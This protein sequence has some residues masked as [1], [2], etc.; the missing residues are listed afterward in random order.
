MIFSDFE[1]FVFFLFVFFTVWYLFPALIWD[2]RKEKRILHIFLLI[3]SYFFYMSWDY[4]FGALI[5]LS[6]FIDYYVGMRLAKTE[7][8]S[9]RLALL[10]F[11]LITNLVFILGFFKYY[12][13][14][15]STTNSVGLHLF[16]EPAL[17]ILNIILPAGISFFTF[18]SLS[19]T[20]DVYRKEI[21]AERDFIKFALFVSFFPQLVAGPIVTAR[22]FVPQLYEIKKFENIEFRIAIRFFMLGYFKKAVL[23][24]QI[25]PTIDLIYKDPTSLHTFTLWIGSVF[26]GIQVYLDFS[27]Y[28]DMA[29]GSA[30]LLGYKLPTNFNLPFIATSVSG[31]WRRWHITLNS[32][33]RDYIYFPMGGSRVSPIRRK[34]NIWF[35]MFASGV[36]HGANWTYVFW[37]SLNGVFYMIEELYKDL[38]GK[39]AVL[40]IS[41]MGNR[42]YSAFKWFFQNTI[43]NLLFFMGAVFFRSSTFENAILHLKG[44]F[45]WQNGLFRPYMWKEFLWIS[46]LVALGHIFG[47]LIFEKKKVTNFPVTFELALY[48]VIIL[49]LCLFTPENSTPFIYF[50]F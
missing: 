46:V 2:E 38:F 13:F 37:G 4:R 29:I 31:F 33:L 27:G 26:G 1:Y 21:P 22:T 42:I 18:Q 9:W 41:S 15:A 3:A 7:S 47:Y 19:Y 35:T 8:K 50:Q 6:T 20:I 49:L 11:S 45:V 5:L 34:F 36:W 32:W 16:G 24:D 30:L 12:N 10:Y 25:A 28:T 40:E 14:L 44:M 43:T 17:P 39:E 48:P 23:S